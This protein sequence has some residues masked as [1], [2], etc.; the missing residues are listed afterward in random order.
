MLR[1]VLWR[2]AISTYKMQT[3]DCRL[4]TADCTLDINLMQTRYKVQIVDWV[5]KADRHQNHLY[6]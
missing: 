2:S 3:A 1:G 4:H 5:L 6:Q